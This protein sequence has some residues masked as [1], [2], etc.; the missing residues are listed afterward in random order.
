MNPIEMILHK[1]PLLIL[2]GAL[3]TELEKHG[4]D[5][6]D[7]LW[8]A[9]VLMEQPELIKQVHCDYFEAGA[10][11]AIT[12]SYQA[13]FKRFQE[14]GL[15]EEEGA[16]LMR[17]SVELAK[18]AR[19]E[20][21]KELENRSGRP[22]PLVAASVGPYGAYLADGS[23]YRGNYGVSKEE[24]KDFHRPRMKELVEAG[25]D[26]LAIETIPS[27]LEAEAAAEV[28]SEFPEAWAW[29]SFSAK[30]EK[31]I[32]DGESIAACAAWADKQD[33]IAAVGVNCTPLQYISSLIEELKQET[34]KPLI[35]YPNSGESYDAETNTWYGDSHSEDFDKNARNWYE[36]GAKIIGGCCRTGPED[37]RR[38]A[39]WGRTGFSG[40]EDNQ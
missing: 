26:I 13:S 22:E 20:F 24:L 2:D 5:L 30:D 6:N 18:E 40:E 29:I 39:S 25:A 28:L 11:F 31:H 21:W 12:A 32:S 37:I 35:V 19:D 3:A 9:K 10:D 1:R 16:A 17:T 27:L 33:Q 4:C 38:I 36:H 34:A 8:S 7:S 15:S 14:R 23:E